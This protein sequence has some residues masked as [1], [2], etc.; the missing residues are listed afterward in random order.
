MAEKKK[1]KAERE[2]EVLLGLVELFLMTGKPVGS[3]TLKENGFEDISSATIRNYFAKLEKEGYLKQQHASGG[4]IPT[5]EAYK[6]FAEHH[7]K[8]NHIDPKDRALLEKELNQDTREIAAYLQN[9]SE[10]L[11][12]LT[13]GAIFLSAPRFDQD[14]IT[15]IKVVG[16]D[17][18]RVLIVIVTDFGLVH[19]EILYTPKKLGQF[20]LKRIESYFHFRLTGLDRPKLS[21]D[22][23]EIASNFYNEI[24]MRHIVG[25]S[26]FSAEDIYK[27]GFSKLIRFPEFRDASVLAT[28]L[29]LFENT[30]FMRKLLGKCTRSGE[31]QVWIGD[32]LH[33][34]SAS[35]AQ[36]SI[37]AIPY[38]IHG[39]AVGA[40]AILGPIRMPYPK[41]FGM[42]RTFS[43]ILSEV[44]TRNL[45][46]YKITYRQVKTEQIE[47][48]TPHPKLIDQGSPLQLED[49][50]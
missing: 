24:M 28:G 18:K 47:M 7:L 46:K 13:Q 48:Q 16:I 49:K 50:T 35:T 29:S 14:I 21:Q 25:Y 26:N 8:C 27:T 42:I 44:L 1:Q 15:D 19:T 11:S 41:I 43:Q 6:L 4:R 10:L 39:K 20:T 23:E 12:H 5:S 22:E 31:M 36:S 45:Y 17:R 2:R 34:P 30:S 37:I 33:H 3:N 9:G 38:F 32:E 40:I